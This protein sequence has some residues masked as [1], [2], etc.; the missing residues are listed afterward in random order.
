MKRF[1]PVA[2]MTLVIVGLGAQPS[3]SM[4]LFPDASAEYKSYATCGSTV[5]PITTQWTIK[6]NKGPIS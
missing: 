3:S 1:F 5:L 6:L 4:F 2:T